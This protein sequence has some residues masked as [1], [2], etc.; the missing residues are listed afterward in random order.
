MSLKTIKVELV[1][2]SW[3]DFEEKKKKYKGKVVRISNFLT[4]THMNTETE[5]SGVRH[6][7]E[8]VESEKK[9]TV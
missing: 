6:E 8:N 1:F 7:F 3:N 4:K 5:V 9:F 2:V